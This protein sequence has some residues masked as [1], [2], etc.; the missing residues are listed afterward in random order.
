MSTPFDFSIKEEISLDYEKLPYATNLSEL[1]KQWR[2]QL[3]L[4]A[5]ERF[6]SKK[7]RRI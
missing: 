2:K 1:K 7:R 6:T 3:K 4:N 5:L